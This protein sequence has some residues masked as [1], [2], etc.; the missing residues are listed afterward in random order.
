MPEPAARPGT[1]A[2]ITF[3]LFCAVVT[4][5]S[6]IRVTDNLNGRL[7]FVFFLLVM[8]TPVFLA[9]G[10]ALTAWPLMPRLASYSGVL[11]RLLFVL[12]AFVVTCGCGPLAISL[13][14]MAITRHQDSIGA[15]GI[16]A[17]LSIVGGIGLSIFGIAVTLLRLALNRRPST[18]L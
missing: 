4:V 3:A 1:S 6:R 12:A 5:A 17:L 2:A 11:E 7:G 18:R 9:T 13:A 15:A 8:V 16:W 10:V 14:V